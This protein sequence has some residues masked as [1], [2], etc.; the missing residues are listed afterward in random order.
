MLKFKVQDDEAAKLQK[1]IK[2]NSETVSQWAERGMPA[3]CINIQQWEVEQL[4]LCN[5]NLN[6]G[7]NQH[8]SIIK[9]IRLISFPQLRILNLSQNK[10][11]SVEGVPRMWMPRLQ[12]LY[13][14]TF[15]VN[16][17]ENRITRVK[18]LRKSSLHLKKLS[19]CNNWVTFS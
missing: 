17:G 6:E 12:E 15:F 9:D 16:A 13:I 11:E 2:R 19:L 3:K 5:Q 18:D 4:R 14:C 1:L 7:E 8:P 10:I